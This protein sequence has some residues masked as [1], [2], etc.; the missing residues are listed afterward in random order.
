MR[1]IIA[2][3]AAIICVLISWTSAKADQQEIVVELFTSQGCSSCPPADDLLAQ[4][5]RR[6][7]VFGLTLAVDYWDYLGWKDQFADKAH[8]ERQ[9]DYQEFLGGANVYTPQ[10]VIGGATQAVGSQ[11]EAVQTAI[12]IHKSGNRPALPIALRGVGGD[13][14]I[15][16]PAG[17]PAGTATVW[18][19]LYDR[20]RKVTV[21]GGEN[22]GRSLNY[23]NVVRGFQRID[24]WEGRAKT[25]TVSSAELARHAQTEACAV[26]VQEWGTGPI[27][28]FAQLERARAPR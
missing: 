17:R 5:D 7:D 3:T 6:D 16:L 9:K 2:K 8:T 14:V 19:V 11:P 10:M 28:G 21:T 25:I 4:L 13:L 24:T 20:D 26:L 27:I 18:L 12:D 23:H 22:G 15:D 1:S